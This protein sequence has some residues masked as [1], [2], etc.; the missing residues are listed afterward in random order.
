MIP[1]TVT[2][3]QLHGDDIREYEAVKRDWTKK[4]REDVVIGSKPV[5][6]KSVHKEEVHQRIGLTGAAQ[7]PQRK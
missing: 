1:P 2:T 7:P 5:V 3:L 6:S 4:P